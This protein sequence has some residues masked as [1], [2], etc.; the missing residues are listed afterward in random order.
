MLQMGDTKFINN[1]NRMKKVE[2]LLDELIVGERDNKMVLFL[3]CLSCFLDQP[4]G[5]IISGEASGGKTHIVREVIKLIPDSHKIILGGATKRALIHMK[6]TIS[7][8]RRSDGLIE[9]IKTIDFSNKILWFLED[10]G[11]EDSYT[12]LRPILSRDQEEIRFEL[13]TKKKSKGGSEFFTN[14]VIIIKGCP[15]FITT[16]TRIERLA[17]TGTRV[18][19]LSPDESKEQSEKVVWFKLNRKR[20][21]K[22]EADLSE[23]HS[24][25]RNLR[26]Y[27]VW[28]PFTD[29]MNITCNNLNIRRDIDKVLALTETVC[30]FNQHERKTIEINGVECLIATLPDYFIAMDYAEKVINPTLE[31]LP[32]KILDFFGQLK[33]IFPKGDFT[34][35]MVAEQTPYNQ[36]TSRNYC[37]QLVIS[38]K[39]IK[40]RKDGSKENFYSYKQDENEGSSVTC[41]T[42][43]KVTPEMV[44]KSLLDTKSFLK[45]SVTQNCNIGASDI[46]SIIRYCFSVTHKHFSNFD[47]TSFE[48]LINDVAWVKI[49]EETDNEARCVS[50]GIKTGD[51]NE[52]FLCEF[53]RDTS[54][55]NEGGK[56]DSLL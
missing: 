35:K 28:I 2:N 34:N 53:C 27:K 42:L 52:G 46:I 32:K 9:I 5:T 22:P 38:G 6:G 55:G 25:I 16:S 17:E 11:G 4:N 44:A 31:N 56:N 30:L 40:Y 14:D 12:T 43:K 50:C 19:Q 33:N 18:F 1:P 15:A 47:T 48:N 54:T 37:W 49:T 41:V 10:S 24:Y 7:E 45:S 13:P 51:L 26:R 20:F 3:N 29:I 36:E 21:P 39:L 23:I 8:N